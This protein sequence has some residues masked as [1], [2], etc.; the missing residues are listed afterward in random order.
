MAVDRD[1]RV[2]VFVT[3][4]QG[5]VPRLSLLPPRPPVEEIES[6]LDRLPP[7]TTARLLI[8]LKRPDDFLDF[9]RRGFFAY[10]WT[11]VHRANSQALH[12][13]ELIAAPDEA[14]AA[15]ELPKEITDLFDGIALDVSFVHD[16]LIDVS[17]YLSC[18]RPEEKA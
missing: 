15:T 4:G 17:R 5:P 14:V 13:Y 7:C 12:S 8:S 16:R 1:G 9:A 6:Y 11:D 3:G 2:G 10:D 18:R